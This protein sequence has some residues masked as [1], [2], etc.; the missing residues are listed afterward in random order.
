MESKKSFFSVQNLL[1]SSL[2]IVALLV[3]MVA[4]TPSLRQQV[5]DFFTPEHRTILAKVNG[6]LTGDGLKVMVLKIRTRESLV[7]EI[8]RDEMEGMSLMAKITLPEKRDAYFLLKGNATNLG[9]AD[10]DSDGVLE[11]LAPTFDDQMVARLNI[12][13][14]NPQTHSFDRVNAPA[15]SEF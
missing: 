8:Y 6:D 11:I 3:T 2:V 12:Y 9:L 14:Y 10:V 1:L 5:R 15:N 4:I 7:L 13:K